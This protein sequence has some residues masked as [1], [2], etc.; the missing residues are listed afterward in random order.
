MSKLKRSPKNCDQYLYKENQVL[1]FCGI[2]ASHRISHTLQNPNRNFFECLTS[3]SK[4]EKGC[5]YFDCFGVKGVDVTEKLKMAILVESLTNEIHD[6]Q[7][8]NMELQAS[9]TLAAPQTSQT[10]SK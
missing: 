5:G 2:R 10:V 9:M 8:E 6:I 4:D 3:K 7:V 1:C